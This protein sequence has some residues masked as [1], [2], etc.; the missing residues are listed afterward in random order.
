MWA[1]RRAE[2]GRGQEKTRAMTKGP[3]HDRK[4]IEPRGGR[5]DVQGEW[6][7]GVGL[8]GAEGQDRKEQD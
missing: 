8:E 4:E 1:W 3:S 5:G 6:D 2:S 7:A